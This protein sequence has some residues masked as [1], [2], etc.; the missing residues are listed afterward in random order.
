MLIGRA[1]LEMTTRY[2]Q[3][4]SKQADRVIKNSRMYL[5][6]VGSCQL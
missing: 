1:D 4:V 6:Q 3:D 2:V 5:C